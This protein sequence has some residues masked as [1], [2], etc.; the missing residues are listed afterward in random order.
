M[1]LTAAQAKERILSGQIDGDH[2]VIENLDMSWC[3]IA[4]WP[5]WKFREVTMQ[6]AKIKTIGGTFTFLDC[7]GSTLEKIDP[8]MHVDKNKDGF[9]ARF[10]ACTNLQKVQGRFNGFTNWMR[11]GI[12]SIDPKTQFGISYYGDCAEFIDCKQLLK[13]QGDFPGFTNWLRSGILEI[14]PKTKFGVNQDGCSADFTD[15]SQL[16]P[17]T[18]AIPPKGNVAGDIRFIPKPPALGAMDF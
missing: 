14:D 17:I 1:K 11:S 8:T 12:T 6:R 7:S 16:S 9:S 4:A 18:F 10:I 15:C 2:E 3:K 5:N 13:A